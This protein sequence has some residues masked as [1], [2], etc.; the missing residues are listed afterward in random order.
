VKKVFSFFVEEEKDRAPSSLSGPV[1]PPPPE[2]L[3]PPH[4]FFFVFHS[5]AMAMGFHDIV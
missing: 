2:A 3:L 4:A 5:H 1:L